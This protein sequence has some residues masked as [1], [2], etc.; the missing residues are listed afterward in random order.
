MA[1]LCWSCLRDTACA[2]P[3]QQHQSSPGPLRPSWCLPA[4]QRKGQRSAVSTQ[5]LHLPAS[6][7]AQDQVSIN[8]SAPAHACLQC[9]M[10]ST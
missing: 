5:T 8:T 2:F 10:S 3:A 6:N 7:T 4:E 1:R 9:S